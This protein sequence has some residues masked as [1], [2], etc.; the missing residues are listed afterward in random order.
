[1]DFSD[2]MRLASISDVMTPIIQTLRACYAPGTVLGIT[3]TVTDETDM[4]LALKECIV[5]R[6]YCDD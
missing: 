3:C 4:G 5:S 1:M 2:L 6:A